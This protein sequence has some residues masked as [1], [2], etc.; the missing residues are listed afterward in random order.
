MYQIPCTTTHLSIDRG[1]KGVYKK[2]MGKWGYINQMKLKVFVLFIACLFIAVIIVAFIQPSCNGTDGEKEPQP[3]ADNISSPGPSANETIIQDID[4]PRFS[5]E[6]VSAIVYSKLASRLPSNYKIDQFDQSSRFSRYI[7]NGKWEFTI[8]GSEESRT[9]LPDEKVEPSE[10]IWIIYEK[11]E[12]SKCDLFL[13]AEY[14][15]KLD[16]CEII[17]IERYT[18]KAKIIIVSERT[19][20]AELTVTLKDYENWAINHRFQVNVKNSGLIPIHG[21]KLK[22]SYSEPKKL[23]LEEL[24]YEGTLYPEKFAALSITFQDEE[25]FQYYYPDDYEFFT[26]SGEKLSDTLRL[27][28]YP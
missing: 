19:F 15:E 7:G 25:N 17:S 2:D 11:D 1:V 14:F 3:Q 9:K 12:V 26:G 4:E 24:V 16:L 18:P 8:W 6:E 5:D 22:I 27:S 13:E 20:K 28:A 21:I 10:T 23:T